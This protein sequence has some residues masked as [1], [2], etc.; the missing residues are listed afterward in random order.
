MSESDRTNNPQIHGFFG[1]RF[2]ITVFKTAEDPSSTNSETSGTSLPAA[3][4]N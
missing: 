4:Y 1:R 3:A 2:N